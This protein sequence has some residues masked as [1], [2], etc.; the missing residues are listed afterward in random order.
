MYISKQ[1]IHI[2]KQK[3]L[4][5]NIFPL[6]YFKCYKYLKKIQKNNNNYIK[7]NINNPIFDNVVNHS[8]DENQRKI[9]LEDEDKLIIAGAG[10][11]K[12]ITIIG[13]IL[14]LIKS[15][16]N[17]SEILCLS[18]TNE[19]CSNIKEK[20]LKHNI[21]INV[22]TFHKLSLNILKEN[23]LKYQI[24]ND[25]TLEN[26]IQSHTYHKDKILK[27]YSEPLFKSYDKKGKL[28]NDKELYKIQKNIY[29]C[30]NQYL[31]IKNKIKKFI[32]LFKS[33]GMKLKDFNIFIKD[34]ENELSPALKQVNKN[35]LTLTK[36]IYKCYSSE[37]QCQNKIDFNDM[38]NFAIKC[39]K[40]GSIKKYKYIIIDE[41]QDI[42]EVK[43]E[44][45]KEIKNKT[46][47][48]IFA[49]GDD[50]QSIYRFAGSNLKVFLNFKNY[51][52]YSEISFLTKTYRNSTTLLDI[53]GTFIMKNN[54]QIKKRLLSEINNTN[55]IKI[56][57]YENDINEVINKAI[58]DIGK[59]SIMILGR[60]NKDLENI[61][62]KRKNIKYL[63]VHKSKGRE[64]DN[65]IILNLNDANDGFPSKIKLDNIFKYVIRLKE[66]YPYAEERRLFYVA[67]TRTKN[68]NY[69]LVNRSKPSIFI[70]ELLENNNLSIEAYPTK[71][72][73]CRTIMYYKIKGE[74]LYYEC[75]KCQKSTIIYKKTKQN[76]NF[77]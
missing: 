50:F 54:K 71:C 37:L 8:L 52:P 27:L 75:P 34:T 24:S 62:I 39:V 7:N 40:K 38:I 33:N 77:C 58:Y 56:Y 74:K 72:N 70:K 55:P 17:P 48:K 26:I 32:T 42:S 76:K 30:S 57:Y 46:N 66:E 67:L 12:T 35:F 16:I 31:N 5:S 19:A 14:Y 22:L 47:A 64:S 44:L 10:T 65:V 43:C 41:Y 61:N 18:L 49:V 53:M 1:H 25:N 2:E 60:N 28:K 36:K 45:L 59:G 21:D 29:F 63:T 23:G 69:L 13:K 9:I 6:N 4:K 73:E 3:I 20:C 11:G 15:G 68:N 51:F